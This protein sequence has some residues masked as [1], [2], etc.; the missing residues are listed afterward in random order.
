MFF[1]PAHAEAVKKKI[2]K[3]LFP[4]NFSFSTNPLAQ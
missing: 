4:L 3:I 1:F 2:L